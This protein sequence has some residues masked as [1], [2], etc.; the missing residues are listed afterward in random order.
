MARMPATAFRWR[1]G[2]FPLALPRRWWGCIALGALLTSGCRLP[3]RDGPVP[4][5]LA[6]CRQLSQRGISA[7]ERQD[8]ASAESLF[9]QAVQ[10]CGVDP[11]ARRHFAEALW[12]Q[13][14]QRK[15]IE[16]LDEAIR[17]AGDDERLYVRAAEMRLATGDLEGASEKVGIAIDLDP[18][19]AGAWVLQGKILRERNQ[20][21]EALAAYYRALNSTPE[22][23]E[24]LLAL[25]ETYRVMNDPQ[26]ALL[27][28]H[29]LA[30]TYQTGDEP[31]NVLY[32]QGLA[33][34]ALGRHADAASVLLMARERGPATPE[35][36]NRLA[37][38]ELQAGQFVAARQSV[39]QVLAIDPQNRLARTTLDRL[40]VAQGQTVATGF[41]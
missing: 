26:R 23:R 41:R 27:K 18:Q 40:N 2:C 39:E 32:L 19:S 36:L 38:A 24:V 30:D 11:D 8:W 10:T 25:A 4:R 28:L 17:L 15:A 13:G 31:Q 29:N 16:Q 7:E 3:S 12:H 9:N 33:L 20:P 35:L 6:S 34:S 5:S 1:A 14:H 21:R 37:E 22:D